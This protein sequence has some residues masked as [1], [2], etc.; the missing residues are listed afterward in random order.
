MNARI[1]PRGITLLHL[2]VTNSIH[3]WEFVFTPLIPELKI[4]TDFTGISALD[5]GKSATVQFLI[6]NLCVNVKDVMSRHV[7]VTPR[8]TQLSQF[9]PRTHRAALLI[10]TKHGLASNEIQLPEN[11]YAFRPDTIVDR[12]L[13]LTMDNIKVF[14]DP[15][16]PWFLEFTQHRWNL[17]S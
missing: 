10:R 8:S 9:D 1:A 5:L 15:T 16:S 2:F 7:I 12:G 11:L 4:I 13:K 3:M 14:S 6:N 17:S